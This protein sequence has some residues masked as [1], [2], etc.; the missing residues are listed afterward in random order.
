MSLINWSLFCYVFDWKA[1]TW[2]KLNIKTQQWWN[3]GT[4]KIHF[5]IR[6]RDTFFNPHSQ[7]L[8]L[9]WRFQGDGLNRRISAKKIVYSMAFRIKSAK[10]LKRIQIF[11]ITTSLCVLFS[12]QLWY[13]YIKPGMRSIREWKEG[14]NHDIVST[15]TVLS[16]VHVDT[17]KQ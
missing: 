9:L 16:V 14:K 8:R 5:T 6:N 2:S 3:R 7:A 10:Q 12:P 17:T 15:V 1:F 11:A 13:I 4:K